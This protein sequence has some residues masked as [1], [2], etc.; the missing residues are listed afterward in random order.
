MLIVVSCFKL[1]LKHDSEIG[2]KHIFMFLCDN[3]LTL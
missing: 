2:E 3:N 1:S